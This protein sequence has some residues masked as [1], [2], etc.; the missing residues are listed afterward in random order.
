MAN[1]L[2]IALLAVLA[3]T[4]C[5][6]QS[7]PISQDY[8]LCIEVKGRNSSYLA[9]E[10]YEETKL[11]G[12]GGDI[13]VGVSLYPTNPAYSMVTRHPF[14]RGGRTIP[15]TKAVHLLDIYD[16]NS[17]QMLGVINSRRSGNPRLFI[18]IVGKLE[19][20]GEMA[21]IFETVHRCPR[22]RGTESALKPTR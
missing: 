3:L 6:G 11:T 5:Q 12:S 8:G 1:K 13:K 20:R 14:I 22:A 21:R 19:L 4:S 7:V 9:P 16:G 17:V 15:D 10:D 18:E 2:T